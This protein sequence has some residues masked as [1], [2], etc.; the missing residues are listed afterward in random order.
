MQNAE[1]QAPPTILRRSATPRRERYAQARRI[2]NNCDGKQEV[3]MMKEVLG[4]VLSV[5]LGFIPWTGMAAGVTTNASQQPADSIKTKEANMSISEHCSGTWTPGLTDDEKA[6]LF[7]IAKDT[8]AWCVNG[9]G[10]G[11]NKKKGAFPI[12]SYTITPK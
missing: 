10:G 8:L 3:A 11:I 4:C 1:C 5:L 12:E 2:Q 7:A 9:A 6:T